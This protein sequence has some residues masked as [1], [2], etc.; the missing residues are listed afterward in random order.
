MR[1]HG[2]LPTEEEMPGATFPP[3]PLWEQL[4]QA[5]EF[6]A[7]GPTQT[8]KGSRHINIGEL[9]AALKAEAKVG[10]LHPSTR[11]LQL[12]ESQVALGALVKGR[13][14]SRALNFELVRSLPD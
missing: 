12:L 4:C 9:R 10:R 14:S 11:Y 3:N 1:S 13:A 6:D 2:E 7:F 8:V 5:L